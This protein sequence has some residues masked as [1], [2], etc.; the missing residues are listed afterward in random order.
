MRKTA[1]RIVQTCTYR[2]KIRERVPTATPVPVPPKRR[3]RGHDRRDEERLEEAYQIMKQS[4]AKEQPNEC[5]IYSKHIANKLRKYTH[6]TRAQ[7]EWA[8]NNILFEADM[9]M[10]DQAPSTTPSI[11][12]DFHHHVQRKPASIIPAAI[13][14][15]LNAGKD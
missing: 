2:R 4:T 1:L 7:V 14:N 3:K 15:I 5:D 13:I 12:H 8:I 11:R 9:G 6:R 10:F